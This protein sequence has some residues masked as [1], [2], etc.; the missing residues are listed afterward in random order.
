[1]KIFCGVSLFNQI[2]LWAIVLSSEIICVFPPLCYLCGLFLHYVTFTPPLCYL[3]SSIMLPLFLHYVTFGRSFRRWFVV[4]GCFTWLTRPEPR[5]YS[6]GLY[7]YGLHDDETEHDSLHESAALIR[8][9][10]EDGLQHS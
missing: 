9:G 5:L 8:D 4:L 2:T 7:S 1:M 10:L 6:D 3:C